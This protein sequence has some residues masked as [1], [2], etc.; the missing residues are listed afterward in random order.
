MRTPFGALWPGREVLRPKEL[1]VSVREAG[2][3]APHAPVVTF[4]VE[5]RQRDQFTQREV[6]GKVI[7]RI[8]AKS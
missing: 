7:A 6:V 4:L 2:Y 1:R 3:Q 8:P 5:L